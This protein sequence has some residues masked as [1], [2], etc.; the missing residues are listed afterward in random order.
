MG[1]WAFRVQNACTPEAES[2]SD[3][4]ATTIFR[5]SVWSFAVNV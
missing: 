1:L 5:V 3:Y 4:L 2:E